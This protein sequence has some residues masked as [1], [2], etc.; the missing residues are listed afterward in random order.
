MRGG[1]SVQPR[2]IVSAAPAPWVVHEAELTGG[3]VVAAAG[4]DDVVRGAPSAGRQAS[5][6]TKGSN[7]W[8]QTGLA[9]M[10]QRTDVATRRTFLLRRAPPRSGPVA[11]V[12]AK[13]DRYGCCVGCANAGAGSGETESPFRLP[14]REASRARERSAS[15]SPRCAPRR[16]SAARE[17]GG[18]SCVGCRWHTASSSRSSVIPRSSTPRSRALGVRNRG[19]TR[20][21]RLP[22]CG[23][24][25][26][27]AARTRE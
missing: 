20:R 25:E 10:L 19:R 15:P 5:Q 27:S 14:R 4:D 21:R 9:G 24:G 16:G 7:G 6:S 1:R 26:R 12:A 13:N 8:R 17:A 23:R 11:R 2:A 18:E 3:A 22:P